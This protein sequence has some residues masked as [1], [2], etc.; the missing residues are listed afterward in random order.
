MK[1]RRSL[2]LR[3]AGLIWRLS[4]VLAT[5]AGAG[6]AL[7]QGGAYESG[8]QVYAGV[9]TL[10]SERIEVGGGEIDVHFADPAKPHHDEVIA[11]VRRSAVALSTYFGR[12][13]VRRL[14]LLIVSVDGEGVHGGTTFGF[15]GSA[16]RVHVGRD[17]SAKSFTDDWILVH[18]MV[19]AS[20]PNVPRHS[21]WVQEGQAVYVEPIARA[22]AGLLDPREV[23]RWALIGMPKGEPADGDL[24]LDGTHTWGRT[25]WGGA[26]FWMRAD[27]EIRQRTHNRIGLQTA[28]RTINRESGG[29]TAEWSVEQLMA[30]GD[31]ATG[32]HE[33]STLY[34]SL[35]D[36]PEPMDLA[37]VF[38]QLGVAMHVDQVAFDDRAPLADIRRAI[39]APP[40]GT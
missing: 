18:E 16:I 25:Y 30:T 7:A 13:P 20:L 8:A 6:F 40:S 38:A 15:D 1:T 19:H 3:K 11:W 12:F 10:P 29:N 37:A 31:A 17:T 22:Q 26:A 34:Q 39:T 5:A 32:G 28:L 33:L 23:W 24:G 9:R 14:D 2:G 35:K 4:A 36:Q 21:L 27:I